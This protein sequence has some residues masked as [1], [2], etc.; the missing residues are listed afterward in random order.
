KA[1]RAQQR[2]VE[3]VGAVG[4]RHQDDAGVVVKAVH[5]DEKLV[6][7]LLALLVR[8]GGLRAAALAANRVQFV[9]KDDARGVLARLLEQTADARRADAD[10]HLNKLRAGNAEERDAGL[11]GGRTRQQRLARAR[12]ADEQHALRRA[13]AQALV[14][15]RR[16]EV[17]GNL[18]Q[19]HHGFG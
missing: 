9:D 5:L 4:G 11:A 10:V 17:V 6:Q 13:P 2:R 15:L 19:L 1:A 18:T 3:H 16:F 14:A 12:R 8:V 7:R